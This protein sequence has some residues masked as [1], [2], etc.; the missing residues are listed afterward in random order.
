MNLYNCTHHIFFHQIVWVLVKVYAEPLDNT[1]SPNIDIILLAKGDKSTK[2][3]IKYSIFTLD[4][5][6]NSKLP[7]GKNL[8]TVTQKFN[9]LMPK[10]KQ[11]IGSGT[12]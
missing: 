4:C 1:L 6:W 8:E 10:C 7:V 12:K 11:F 5:S 9:K 2:V 3:F